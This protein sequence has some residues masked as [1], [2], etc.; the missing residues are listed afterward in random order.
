MTLKKYKE[1]RRFTH[2]PEPIPKISRKLHKQL[3]FV[4]QKHY[5]SRLHYDFRLEL[6]GVL[7]SWAVPKGPSMNPADKRLAIMV[8]D[9]PF[10]YRDFE[11]V[12]PKGNYGA[13]KVMIWDEGSYEP[14][15]GEFQDSEKNI[16]K[17]LE[18]G[19]IHFVLHG[20]KLK[21]AFSLIKLRGTQQKNN[22]ILK[23]NSDQFSSQKDILKSDKSVRTQRTLEKID[24]SPVS[25]T[26]KTSMPTRVKPML[27][28]LC[29]QPFDEEGWI[30][31]IKWDGFRIISYLMEKMY[32]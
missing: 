31:E 11:G 1:K 26:K 2:T 10:E 3:H 15:D 30:F 8:E 23:K 20:K 22:W 19:H 5:A 17:D 25:K 18:K 29:T 9:H 13:G 4:I 16:V 14:V 27:A 12:I 32:S 24:A 7:K 6:R 21:G 28:K